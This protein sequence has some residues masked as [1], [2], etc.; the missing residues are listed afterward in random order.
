MIVPRFDRGAGSDLPLRSVQGRLWTSRF[1]VGATLALLAFLAGAKW[2]V[3][4]R[5]RS[6]AAGAPSHIAAERVIPTGELQPS[7]FSGLS[8]ALT[9][10]ANT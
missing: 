4:E 7:A 8:R 6:S 3:S 1:A 5:S 9:S 10:S 2:E